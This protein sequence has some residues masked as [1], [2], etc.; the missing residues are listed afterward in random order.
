[1]HGDAGGADRMALG[2]E[3]AGGIDRQLAVLGHGAF[4]D[5]ARA[6]SFRSQAHGFVLDQLGD[7]EAVVHLGEGEVAERDPGARQRALPGHGAAFE[8]ENVAP[9][10]RQKVLHVLGGAEHDRLAE[11]ERGVDIG[12]HHSGGAVRN[13]RAIGALE[14]AGDARVL[15]AFGAAEFVAEILAQLRVRVADAVLVVLGGDLRQRIRLVAPALKI[16]AGDFSKKTGEAAVDV[17][18][19]AHIGGL[20]QIA[21]DLGGRRRRHLLDADHKHDARGPRRDRLEPLMHGG[22][23]GGA[24]VLDPRGAFEAQIG[25][26]LQHQR[27]GEILRREAGIEMAEHDL[28]DVLG[29]NAGVGERLARHPH[30]QAL[31]RFTGELAEWRMRPSYDAG[32]HGHSVA[33]FRSLSLGLSRVANPHRP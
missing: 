6:L 13:R 17:G 22:G 33:E 12:E 29:C 9:R 19:L 14:R 21:A 31:D 5:D 16:E 24:G 23:T 27:S 8:F 32:C 15:L 10:H 4:G 26:G 7:G 11:F 18:F 30:D 28:V 2:L 20:E 3:A 25:R 1:M